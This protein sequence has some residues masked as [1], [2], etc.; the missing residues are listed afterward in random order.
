MPAVECPPH[1]AKGTPMPGCIFCDLLEAE[2]PPHRIY[3]DALTAAFVDL[4]Q[5]HPGHVLVMP[6]RHVADVRDLDEAT[7][8]ALM[9]AVS[10]VTRAVAAAFPH[11]GISLWHSIGPAAFQEVPHLH[12][13]VHPRFQGDDFLRVYPSRPAAPGFDV[14]GDYAER[15]RMHQEP[16]AAPEGGCAAP[17]CPPGDV[18]IRLAG[19]GDVEGLVA[20]RLAFLAEVAGADAADAE[21][22]RTLREYFA[23]TLPSGEFLAFVAFAGG[24]MVA[25][26]GMVIHRTPPRP[27]NR[28]GRE[29]YIMNM[30]TLPDYRGRGLATAL[31]ARLT[32]LAAEKGCPRVSLH[33]LPAGRS[34]YLKAG[35]AP[36]EAQLRLDL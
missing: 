7:G 35:F 29:G 13:H 1:P 27:R 16:A 34:M 9:A 18:E 21:L 3:R 12:I 19:V 4:R 11:E 20:L 22:A 30:Y 25:C 5:F 28:S 32:A 10:R 14:L 17:P 31:L 8:A 6:R 33:A 23:E 24:R 15:V 2:S 36:D 26:S